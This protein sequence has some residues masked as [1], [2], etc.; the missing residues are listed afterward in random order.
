MQ[1]GDEPEDADPGLSNNQRTS[2]C[3]TYFGGEKEIHTPDFNYGA[4]V[5][6]VQ[7]DLIY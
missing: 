7:E 4:S 3:G 2:G 6:C 5:Y 1:L